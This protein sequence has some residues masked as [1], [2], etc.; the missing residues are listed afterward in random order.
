M[1]PS[2]ILS[3]AALTML[4]A[5]PMTAS[6]LESDRDQPIHIEADAAT[7][8]QKNGITTYSGSVKM[9]QGSIHIE[10]QKV[11]IYSSTNKVNKIIATGSP[12]RFQQQPAPEKQLIIAMG[13]SLVYEVANDTLIIKENGRI[14]QDGSVVTGD[15]IDYD[16]RKS[17]VQANGNASSNT[18]VK[19]VLQPQPKNTE[20]KD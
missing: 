12:A 15:S 16:I 5:L 11:V 4:S 7:R 1:S 10:A 17:L 8:D 13:N 18:R 6:A 19:M 2:K 9:D 14:E 3:L 20:E